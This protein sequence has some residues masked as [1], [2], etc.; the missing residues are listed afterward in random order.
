MVLCYCKQELI[1]SRKA[2]RGQTMKNLEI[3]EAIQKK[4]LRHYEVAAALGVNPCTFSRWMYQQ[5]LSGDRKKRV[6]D[7]IKSI[8]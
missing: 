8:K 4:R 1:S 7:A 5:E 2:E 3:R 6:L